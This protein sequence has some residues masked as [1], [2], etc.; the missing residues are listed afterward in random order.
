M[1]F[2]A[3]IK[4]FIAALKLNFAYRWG[5]GI[6]IPSVSVNVSVAACIGIYCDAWQWATTAVADAWRE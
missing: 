4:N 2:I 5:K 6:P 1:P 3:Q